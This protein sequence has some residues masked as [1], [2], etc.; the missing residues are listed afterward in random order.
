MNIERNKA[1]D[2]VSGTLAWLQER[3]KTVK[4]QEE[5]WA[6]VGV[7]A[8][9]QH[10][11]SCYDTFNEVERYLRYQITAETEESIRENFKCEYEAVMETDENDK[12]QAEAGGDVEMVE[13]EQS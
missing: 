1:I 7:Y 8:K 9:A 2:I 12:I 13:G 5:L 11:K 6:R 4:H 10:Y 3:E